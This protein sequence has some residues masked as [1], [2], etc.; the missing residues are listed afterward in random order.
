MAM[1]DAWCSPG[2]H[3]ATGALDE[4]EES[5]YLKGTDSLA[6]RSALVP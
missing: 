4:D 1:F 2:H 3:N 5:T 6:R